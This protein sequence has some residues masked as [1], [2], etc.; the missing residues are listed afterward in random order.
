MLIIE[1]SYYHIKGYYRLCNQS[2]GIHQ[3]SPMRE[4]DGKWVSDIY[5]FFLKYVSIYNYIYSETIILAM[6]S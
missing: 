4:K 5:I 2:L 3:F 1:T 6:G